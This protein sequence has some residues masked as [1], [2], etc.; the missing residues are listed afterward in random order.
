MKNLKIIKLSVDKYKSKVYNNTCKEQ[1][2]LL[3]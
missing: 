2:N 3:R 1:V